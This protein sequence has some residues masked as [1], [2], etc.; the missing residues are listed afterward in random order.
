[1][2]ARD[3]VDEQFRDVTKHLADVWLKIDAVKAAGPTD[4]LHDLL[5]DLEKTVHKV[6]TGGMIGSGAKGHRKALEKW[7][8]LQGI[9]TD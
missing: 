4:N 8:K 5:E 2:K 1:M 6:R 9:E 3:E 7:H